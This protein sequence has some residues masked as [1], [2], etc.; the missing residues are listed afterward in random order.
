[1]TVGRD[2]RD[3][4]S[5]DRQ[6]WLW[7]VGFGAVLLAVVAFVLATDSIDDPGMW[8]SAAAMAA[9]GFV[10]ALIGTRVMRYSALW[11]V[12]CYFLLV[13]VLFAVA[14]FAD[15]NAAAL[16]TALI[17]HA[18]MLFGGWPRRLVAAVALLELTVVVKLA[19][20]LGPGFGT[21]ALVAA[22]AVLPGVMGT[23]VA[24]WIQRIIGQSSRRA[25][26]IAE[27]DRTRE[28]LAAER[29]RA[30]VQ[31]ERARMA[32]E[33]H[34]TLVQ[35]FT[36]IAMLAES[37]RAELDRDASVR[38]AADT[39]ATIER[40]ARENVAEARSLVAALAP[41][42]LSGATLAE[43]LQRLADKSQRELGVPVDFAQIGGGRPETASGFI[44]LDVVL[45][46]AAQEALHNVGKHAAA[47][48]VCV[49]L[50]YSPGRVELL[51]SDDGCGFQRSADA[52]GFGLRGMRQRIEAQ[53]GWLHVDSAPGA[54]T[55]LRVE[56]PV[57]GSDDAESDAGPEVVPAAE[58]A[59]GAST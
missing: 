29:H 33:I 56:L 17:P 47:S 38:T 6:P 30:G 50:R 4:D 52:S 53:G 46:R 12:L 18:G 7:H 40:T 5:W 28:E 41:A 9:I 22:V 54:G 55:R 37:A 19:L 25:A 57:R 2:E 51:V 42:E 23:L 16:L 59:A 39:V 36:S 49:E 3:A 11:P 14:V 44:D 43:A 15:A 31:A 26:L 58:V 35:G 48:A 45:L 20:I 1:M 21:V 27:L 13:V 24:I 34:D 10:Y 32:A 8:V